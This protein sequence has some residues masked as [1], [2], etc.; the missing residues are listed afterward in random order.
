MMNSNLFIFSKY[1]F[2][3]IAYSALA[4]IVFYILD[5]EFLATLTFFV[6]LFFLY[7]FRNPERELQLFENTSVLAPCDGV[8]SSIEEL[9]DEEYRYKIEIE[10]SFTDIG[11]LRA[12]MSA[13]VSKVKLIQGTHLGKDSKLFSD[14]NEYL[15]L[16]FVD[17]KN[18]SV[19]VVH[20]LKQSVLP[21]FFDFIEG[22]HC[23][24][25]VRYGFASNCTTT[26]YLKSNV[27][28]DLQVAQRVEASQSLVA[29]FS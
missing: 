20:R 26:I 4:F 8:V 18:N 12:P 29:Y 14:L 22:Q 6:I 25:S 19:K 21:V 16:E 2:N 1:S 9:E 3:Y 7:T 13:K 24:R 27:R 23:V 5:L 17:E 11:V 28:V 10:S 15:E